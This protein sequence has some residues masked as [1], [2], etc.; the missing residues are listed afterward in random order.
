MSDGLYG[1][2]LDPIEVRPHLA[3]GEQAIERV[4]RGV[5]RD[6]EAAAVFVVRDHSA[7]LPGGCYSDGRRTREA[8]TGTMCVSEDVKFP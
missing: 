3:D 5:E 8:P 7:R 2:T 4:G 1:L 6:V